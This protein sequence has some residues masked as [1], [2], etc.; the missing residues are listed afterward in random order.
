MYRR[1]RETMSPVQIVDPRN[2]S[3]SAGFTLVELLV[4]VAILG[5]LAALAVGVY[6][7]Q[8]DKGRITQM[9]ELAMEVEQGQ[10]DYA[11]RNGRYFSP[12]DTV[13][14]P[15]SSTSDE[16]E[17][18]LQFDRENLN[19]DI[20][21][22]TEAGTDGDNCNIC[23]DNY[24]PDTSKNWYAIQVCRDLDGNTSGGKDCTTDT[25]V[26]LDNDLEQPA[27]LREGK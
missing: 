6:T 27:V 10:K 1:P 25:T 16:W 12:S 13:Y 22:M 19:P 11:S 21:V 2:S 14:D 17:E 24:S 8:L 20:R 5:I 9:K 18:L 15:S 7:S 4:V 23:K 26:Y 3:T